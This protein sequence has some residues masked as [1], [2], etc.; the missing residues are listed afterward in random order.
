MVFSY[1]LIKRKGHSLPGINESS[2]LRSTDSSSSIGQGGNSG[3]SSGDSTHVTPG[4]SEFLMLMVPVE[5]FG[6]TG[7]RGI[8]VTPGISEFLK[9]MVLVEHFGRGLHVKPGIKPVF[10]TSIESSI[11]HGGKTTFRKKRMRH[12]NLKFGFFY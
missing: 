12:Y 2:D 9:S 11:G 5:H 1:T 3:F 8:H 6:S 10:P 4:I 7:G